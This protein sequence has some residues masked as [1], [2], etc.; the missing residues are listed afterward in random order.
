MPEIFITAA[1]V[2]ELAI[3]NQNIMEDWFKDEQIRTAQENFILPVLGS[4][5]DGSGLY[6][7]LVAEETLTGDYKT[8]MEEYIWPALAFYVKYQC[9]P[10]IYTQMGDAGLMQNRTDY[11]SGVS[12]KDKEIY[13]NQALQDGHTMVTRMVRWLNLDENS[14]KFPQWSSGD[15]INTKVNYSG[16]IIIPKRRRKKGNIYY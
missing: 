16:G 9:A 2:I 4:Y 1:K 12:T 5:P 15:D 7:Y 13:R 10:D 6:D 8:L 11:S 14:A 3:P